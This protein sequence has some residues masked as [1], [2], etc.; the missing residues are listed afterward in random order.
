M[1]RRQFIGRRDH[2]VQQPF[3]IFQPGGGNNDRVAFAANFFGDTQKPSARILLER[4]VK[5][6]PFNLNLLGFKRVLLNEWTRWRL[7]IGLVIWLPVEGRW[8]FV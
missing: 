3:E 6:L 4:Q 1:F 8:P 7:H 5:R 2:L